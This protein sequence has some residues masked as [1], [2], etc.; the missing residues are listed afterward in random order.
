[1]PKPCRT[2][3]DETVASQRIGTY[4]HVP[5]F[6]LIPKSKHSFYIITLRDPFPR[7]VSAFVYEH[8]DNELARGENLTALSIEAKTEARKCFPS[9][10]KFVDWIGDDVDQY[11]YPYHRSQIVA[12]NCTDLAR[13]VMNGKVRRFNHF[14]FSFQKIRSL[15]PEEKHPPVILATRQEHLWYDWKKINY[16][17]GQHGNVAI[18]KKTARNYTSIHQ[19]V[20]RDLSEKGKR[21]FCKALQK[22]YEAYVKL[23]REAV[24]L[25]DEDVQESLDQIENTCPN[26]KIPD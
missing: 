18:P 12:S 26:V 8:L 9:L 10:E 22:E 23:L 7:S 1:M 25:S 4:Y 13:A 3:P 19:P 11:N 21:R 17:L 15:I 2:V 6:G 5:D 24:N 20:T 14:F 16:L